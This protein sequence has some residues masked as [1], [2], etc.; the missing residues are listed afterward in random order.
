MCM[1]WKRWLV[2]SLQHIAYLRR[3]FH[4]SIVFTVTSHHVGKVYRSKRPKLFRRTRILMPHNHIVP[5]VARA[6]S[7]CF[8]LLSLMC[9]LIDVTSERVYCVWLVMRVIPLD[10]LNV[11]IV[12][13][14][15]L[16]ANLSM[17]YY[18]FDYA[19]RILVIIIML[20]HSRNST[21]ICHVIAQTKH[22]SVWMYYIWLRHVNKTASLYNRSIRIKIFTPALAVTGQVTHF[23]WRSRAVV[24]CSGLEFESETA[25]QIRSVCT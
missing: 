24:P 3:D 11:R 6:C 12:F 7:A 10:K 21:L 9:A 16:P 25:N 18:V 22:V 23:D 19:A 13:W 15:G 1:S 14:K 4:S 20:H 17:C 2:I 5:V 8:V